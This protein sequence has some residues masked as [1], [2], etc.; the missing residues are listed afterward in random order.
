MKWIRFQTLVLAE[1]SKNLISY[2]SANSCPWV[3]ETTLSDSGISLLLA[4]KIYSHFKHKIKIISL[5][6]LPTPTI[7]IKIYKNLNNRSFSMC[8]NLLDPILHIVEGRLI[9]H[10]IDEED[11][12]SSPVISCCDR[13][14]PLL[15]I[16]TYYTS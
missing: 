11:P 4:S 13:S 7:S 14:K 6:P 15:F 16:S 2:L 5:Q 12:H 3:D 1:V 10:I 9:P 8:I